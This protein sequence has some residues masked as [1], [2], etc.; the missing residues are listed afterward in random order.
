MPRKVLILIDAQFTP[1]SLYDHYSSNEEDTEKR[2]NSV[3][4]SSFLIN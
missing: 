1:D 4:K 3:L 2:F